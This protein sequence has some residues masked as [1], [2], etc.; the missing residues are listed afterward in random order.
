LALCAYAEYLESSGLVPLAR[1][2]P[3]W[4]FLKRGLWSLGLIPMRLTVDFMM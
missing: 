1:N 2:E 3:G 4:I